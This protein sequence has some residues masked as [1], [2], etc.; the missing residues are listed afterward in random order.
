MHTDGQGLPGA[1]GLGQGELY[2]FLIF[3]FNCL[4]G[5]WPIR[6]PGFT[7]HPGPGFPVPSLRLHVASTGC[8]RVR[9]FRDLSTYELCLSAVISRKPWE[10]GR[11]TWTMGI[12]SKMEKIRTCWQIEKST[13]NRGERCL[14]RETC[15]RMVITVIVSEFW[16]LIYIMLGLFG[17]LVLFSCLWG[18]LLSFLYFLQWSWLWVQIV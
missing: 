12:S 3:A 16:W 5:S 13:G 1:Q 17:W 2:R 6:K 4:A 11:M 8:I 7:W 18:V 14:K 10:G 9:V 15:T